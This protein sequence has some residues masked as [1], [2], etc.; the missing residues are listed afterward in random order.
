MI[1][2]LLTAAQRVM[3]S[4]GAAPRGASAAVWEEIS[5]FMHGLAT[6][7]AARWVPE[8]AERI[9]CDVPH[10]KPGSDVACAC[11]R[12]SIGRCDAC[13]RPAC[14]EHARVD[15]S[16]GIIC[17][18]C[19]GEQMRLAAARAAQNPMPRRKHRGYGPRATAGAS[20]PP[21]APERPSV[22]EVRRLA[23][24]ELGLTEGATWAEVRATYAAKVK[25]LHPDRVSRMANAH[26]RQAMTLKYQRVVNAYSWLVQHKEAA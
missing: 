6:R 25:E 5:H 10:M 9:E 26:E 17:F 21:P 24:A 8:L 13:A 15:M 7:A 23:L 1:N 3:G 4:L 20:P 18:V 14:L 2:D 12:F 16:G 19:V 22:E 11:E